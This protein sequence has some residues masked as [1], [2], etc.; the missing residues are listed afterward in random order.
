MKAPAAVL[1]LAVT[2]FLGA[3]VPAAAQL[4]AGPTVRETVVALDPERGIMVLDAETRRELGLFPDVQGFVSATLLRPAAEGGDRWVLEI[5]AR[6][7]GDETRERRALDDA[8]LAALRR[9]I[10]DAFLARGM[11]GVVD[12]EGRGGVVLTSTLLGLG[13]YGWAV[14]DALGVDGDRAVVAGYLLTSGAAFLVPYL[15]TR[16]RPVSRASQAGATWGGTRGIVFGAVLGDLLGLDASD[17]DRSRVRNGVGVLGSAL[18]GVAGFA[19]ASA[20]GHD[21]GRVA[22]AGALGDFALA[23]AF[24]TAYALGLYEAD[25]ECIDDLCVN[26]GSEA[27][28][29]G[30]AFGLGLGA[31]GVALAA[32]HARNRDVRRGDV[33]VLQSSG[34]LGAQLVAPLAHAALGDGGY[35]DERAFAGI[36][37]AGAAAGLYVGNRYGMRGELTPGD[38]LL[39]LAGHLAGGAAALGVTYLIDDGS[40]DAPLYLATSALGSLAGSILTYRAVRGG[41]APERAGSGGGLDVQI[42]PLALLT[43]NPHVASGA[44][45]PWLTIRF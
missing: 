22:L 10:A 2:A 43:A 33:R 26:P 27:T 16:S 13:Y 23:G 32:Y 6:R 15:A 28:T 7:G 9:A 36:L 39:V 45:A 24:T 11:T 4:P 35:D 20:A 21:V 40:S 29:A 30:H 44:P 31:A 37:V 42:R 12:R 14:P 41:A 38:G 34:L 8:G 25:F 3:A 19:Y 17:D 18:T 5:V 1:A